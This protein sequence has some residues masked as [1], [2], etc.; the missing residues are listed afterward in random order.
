MNAQ[1]HALNGMCIVHGDCNIVVVE[2]GPNA[3]KRYKN[4]MLRR[5]RWDEQPISVLT[6]DDAP[7]V[8]N[9]CTLVWEG[10]VRRPEFGHFR[11]HT[12]PTE[13]KCKEVL[14]AQ[15]EHYWELARGFVHAA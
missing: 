15:C 12:C 9:E 10:V 2:G 6:S 13:S 11:M 1:Q 8:R 7:S 3:V 4:L 5:I 14:G